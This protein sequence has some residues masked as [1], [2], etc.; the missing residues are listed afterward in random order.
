M[1]S[2]KHA[3][4]QWQAYLE[5]TFLQRNAHT[6]PREK[7]ESSDTTSVWLGMSRV[8]ALEAIVGLKHRNLFVAEM[9]TPIPF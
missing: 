4:A 2:H 9:N 7:A 8:R 1:C 5:G 6:Q 3:R